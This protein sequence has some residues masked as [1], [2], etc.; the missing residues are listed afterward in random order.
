[1]EKGTPTL[2][3]DAGNWGESRSALSW[4]KTQFIFDEMGRMN[5]DVVTLGDAELA[6]GT[7]ALRTLLASQPQVNVVSANVKDKSG[8]LV[9]P[10][11]LVI[12][13]SGVRFGVTAV[14][15]AS[16]Y[17]FNV[18]RGLQA[19]DE[20][21]FDDPKTA[22]QRVLPKLRGECD[23]VVVLMQEGP[24]NAQKLVDEVSGMDVVIMGHDSG[25][26]PGPDHVGQTLVVR[27]GNRGQYVHSLDLT[28]DGNAK[29]VD[30]AGRGKPL[31]ETVAKDPEFDKIVT[32]W[33]TAF[34]ARQAAEIR[35]QM[36][37]KSR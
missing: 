2:V 12:D 1:M 34:K 33:E 32:E 3:V 9:F 31:V 17:D 14:T 29:I 37:P 8:R 27:P 16:S 7:H 4:D 28:L 15:G 19:V 6:Q 13:K 25:Y 20:F 30:S 5:Y 35:K 26:Q 24:K 21:T 18:T 10:E 11:S 36:P 22:L 23:I